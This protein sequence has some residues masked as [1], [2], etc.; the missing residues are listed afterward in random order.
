[1]NSEATVWDLYCGTGS[2]SLPAALKSKHVTGMELSQS[3][4]NDAKLNAELNHIPNANFYCADLHKKETIEFLKSLPKPD[5]II[6]DPPRAGVHSVL[7]Q[8]LLELAVPRIVYVSCNPATQARD[9]AILAE[10]YSVT[11]LQPIDMFPHTTHVECVARLE[12]R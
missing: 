10:Q 2:I 9:C 6:L 5:V 8:H 12:K 3:S 1:L 7:L 4:I 11:H